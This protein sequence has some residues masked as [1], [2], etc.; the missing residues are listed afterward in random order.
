MPSS[1]FLGS[2]EDLPED[3]SPRS[4]KGS[5][6][7][8]RDYREELRRLEITPESAPYRCPGANG[9]AERFM[10]TFKEECAWLHCFK[11]IEE[12]ERVVNRWIE[13]Y[14]HRRRQSSLGCMTPVE[15][16]ES[17]RTLAA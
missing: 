9:I 16:R 11:T 4:D 2:P 3:M 13:D 10:R 8:A 7:P 6:F 17:L 1:A 5:I 15:Y 14:N 12:A